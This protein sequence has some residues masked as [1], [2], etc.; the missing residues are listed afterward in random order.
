M[1]K[2]VKVD[3]SDPGVFSDFISDD[4]RPVNNGGTTVVLG[5]TE[6]FLDDSTGE[7]VG[8]AIGILEFECFNGF[9][10]IHNI[11]L[12]ETE[13]KKGAYKNVL[14]GFNLL[15]KSAGLE[16]IDAIVFEQ[17]SEG[18]DKI[19]FSK[20][21]GYEL[22]NSHPVYEFT[23][24]TIM[25]GPIGKERK[26]DAHIMSYGKLSQRELRGFCNSVEKDGNASTILDRYGDID[27]DCS[28]VYI[29]D[30]RIVGC[31]LIAGNSDKLEIR[32]LYGAGAPMLL[33]LISSVCH[34]ISQ[35]YGEKV[36]LQAASLGNGIEDMIIKLSG[37]K[38]VKTGSVCHYRKIIF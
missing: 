28:F 38:A 8:F 27:K 7:R 34:A 23:L 3:I 36:I 31:M 25:E 1:I 26:T 12:T 29:K 19:L 4:F 11:R 24:E 18:E 33:A 10:I 17:E 21:N 30:D 2:F 13:E 14:S 37:R 15:A 16:W 35:K 32:W 20:E 5:I 6:V 22:K 9:A